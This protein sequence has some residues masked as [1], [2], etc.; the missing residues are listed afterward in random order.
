MRARHHLASGI[1]VLAWLLLSHGPAFSAE[2]ATPATPAAT[3]PAKSDN[4]KPQIITDEK[5]NTV[6]ILIG[7]KEVLTIGAD[8]IQVY[9]DLKYTGLA[10]DNGEGRTK[11]R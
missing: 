6:R 7:G 10:V 5:T 1:F 3:A 8:G 4:T 2:P 9:G 11:N